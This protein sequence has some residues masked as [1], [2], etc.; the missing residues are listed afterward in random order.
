MLIIRCTLVAESLTDTK[1]HIMHLAKSK[2][3]LP[4]PLLEMINGIVP[5]LNGRDSYNKIAFLGPNTTKIHR[6]LIV[7]YTAKYLQTFKL[8]GKQL[9]NSVYF[10]LYGLSKVAKAFNKPIHYDRTKVAIRVYKKSEQLGFVQIKKIEGETYITTTKEGDE[11]CLKI[12]LDLS[13]LM[14][15]HS[16]APS[17]VEQSVSEDRYSIKKGV[18]PLYTGEK[19]LDTVIQNLLSNTKVLNRQFAEGADAL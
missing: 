1:N 8:I 12:L 13:A 2:N 14:K 9:N 15:I 3:Y 6:Y 7:L 10:T 18:K 17:I 4:E 5:I 19:D 11:I 16:F